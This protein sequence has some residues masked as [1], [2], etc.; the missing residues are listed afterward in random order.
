MGRELDARPGDGRTVHLVVPDRDQGDMVG[1]AIRLERGR[2]IHS[3]P[4]GSTIEIGGG[5]T[6]PPGWT[7]QHGNVNCLWARMNGGEWRI[8]DI[9]RS[10]HKANEFVLAGE[11]AD[12]V[13]SCLCS[14]ES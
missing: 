6:H 4:D 14:E 12:E 7:G 5:N 9:A 13:M 3:Y 8:V 11:N 1:V 2:M 10:R